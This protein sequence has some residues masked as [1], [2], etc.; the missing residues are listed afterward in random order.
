MPRNEK[1][2][3]GIEQMI[4]SALGLDE[5]RGDQIVVVSRPF[6][7][8]V[9]EEPLAEPAPVADLLSLSAAGQVRRCSPWPRFCSTCCCCGR[10]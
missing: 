9:G 3:Q 8:G 7:P 5:K 6:E 10:W 4:K 1:E 2:I